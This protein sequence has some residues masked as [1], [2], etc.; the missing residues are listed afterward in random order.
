VRKASSMN[1]AMVVAARI[2]GGVVE[3]VRVPDG[4]EI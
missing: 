4:G 1:G 3:L 2:P